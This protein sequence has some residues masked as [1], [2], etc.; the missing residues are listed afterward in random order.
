MC[1]SSCDL[2]GVAVSTADTRAIVPPAA[3]GA[4]TPFQVFAE[5]DQDVSWEEY[6]HDVTKPLK[7]GPLY[8]Y[9]NKRKQ[10]V[11][12]ASVPAEEVCLRCIFV[13]FY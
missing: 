10:R 11:S 12:Y 5:T 7:Q 8:I 1:R 2:A 4:P 13:H 3:T 6:Y 9:D